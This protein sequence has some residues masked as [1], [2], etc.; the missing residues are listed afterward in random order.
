MIQT[1][2]KTVVL[3]VALG[4]LHGLLFL[5]V[6]LSMFIPADQFL[7]SFGHYDKVREYLA[8]NLNLSKYFGAIPVRNK[9]M[10]SYFLRGPAG[11]Q[12]I[13]ADHCQSVILQVN[14]HPSLHLQNSSSDDSK[15]EQLVE[16]TTEEVVGM[17]GDLYG[18]LKLKTSKKSCRS[19]FSAA[20]DVK[21]MQFFYCALDVKEQGKVAHTKDQINLASTSDSSSSPGSSEPADS[22]KRLCSRPTLNFPPPPESN[23][24]SST[25]DSGDNGHFYDAPNDAS[26][27]EKQLRYFDDSLQS[28]V[29]I[30]D[31]SS[32]KRHRYHSEY[33][34]GKIMLHHQPNFNIRNRNFTQSEVVQIVL[35]GNLGSRSALTKSIS[36]DNI[37]KSLQSLADSDYFGVVKGD[38]Q[39]KPTLKND[40]FPLNK[41]LPTDMKTFKS[42][43][44]T[45]MML[46]D[47]FHQAT[48]SEST[49]TFS[50]QKDD[51]TVSI[52]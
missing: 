20:A 34:R 27:E 51:S 25:T 19:S 39:I 16:H 32:F 14:R 30:E 48:S 2:V 47:N 8:T 50:M 22:I 13:S 49:S 6:A 38:Q 23:K 35:N 44:K 26:N 36:L 18:F 46:H 11:T 9:R 29:G 21:S 17:A 10:V 41:V 15:S 52:L 3:V 40:K 28:S 33:A 24:T 4:V 5:P 12:E 37:D 45:F 1:F 7:E 31:S 42:S 43:T